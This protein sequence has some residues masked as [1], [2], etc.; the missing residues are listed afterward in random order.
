MS[1][2]QITFKTNQSEAP[3]IE[4][5]LLAAGA[6]SVTYQDAEDQPVLEPGV[7]QTPLWDKI[8]LIGLYPQNVKTDEIVTAIYKQLPDI[9]LA[10]I[11]VS[12][13][14]DQDWE[15]A[16]MA[17]F[18]PMCFADKFW[19]YPSNITPPADQVTMLLDPGLAFGT[20]THPTTAL[21]LEYLA[22]QDLKGKSVIDYGCGSGILAIAAL[23]M[24]ASKAYC[25]DNDPQALQATLDNAERNQINPDSIIVLSPADV[26]HVRVDLLVAN[27]LAGPL[28]D[29]A[30]L[31][32]TLVK[33]QGLITLSGIL[34]EQADTLMAHYEKWFVMTQKLENDGW[35]RLD[36]H[37][38]ES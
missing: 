31:F 28:G 21:C 8:N 33:H 16:W 29:L 30:G 25:V 17:D 23:K 35:V 3:E 34:S 1:W 9:E 32:S 10:V 22:Q 37:K 2:V 26:P 7:G 13:L 18:Q 36:G 19:V 15:R 38:A 11:E 5:A 6:C 24:G 4:A 12:D 14:P 27:I 20:G